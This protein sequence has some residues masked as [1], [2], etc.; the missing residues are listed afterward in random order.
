ML[1]VSIFLCFSLAK[2]YIINKDA[3]I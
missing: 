1:L 2:S 3:P